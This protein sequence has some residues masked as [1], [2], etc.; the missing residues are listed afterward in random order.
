M[1]TLRSA[2]KNAPWIRRIFLLMNG[3]HPL[4]QWVPEPEKTEIV[5]R[6][7]LLPSGHCPTRNG[8]AATSVAALIPGLSEFFIF[9]DDDV[10]V[11]SPVTPDLFFPKALSSPMRTPQCWALS[12]TREGHSIYKNRQSTGLRDAQLPKTYTG[13]ILHVWFPMRKSSLLKFEARYPQ[14]LAFIR[15]HHRGRY[16]STF[17]EHGTRRSET[18]NSNEES[19][20][21][22]WYWWMLATKACGRVSIS[23]IPPGNVID[24]ITTYDTE[25][26]EKILQTPRLFTCINDNL[27]WAKGDPKMGHHA[28]KGRSY[29]KE[30]AVFRSVMEK[31]YPD[32]HGRSQLNFDDNE[33]FR[34]PSFMDTDWNE[35]GT[36][37]WP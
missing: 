12:T 36:G 17:N 14:A 35:N 37:G 11:S 32:P 16:S 13:H 30:L 20:M 15:S 1:Y 33:L 21:G 34:N 5:D 10:L 7:L 24:Q 2:A 8:F 31:F 6:C 18:E 22:I 26:L 9:T 25:K 28:R 29:E 3:A 27:M 23:S 19:L 4:P